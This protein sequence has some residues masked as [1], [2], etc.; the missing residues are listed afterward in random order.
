VR[1][2]ANE[3]VDRLGQ[4]GHNVGELQK[5][6]ALLSGKLTNIEEELMQPKNSAHQDTENFPTKLDNQLAYIYWMLDATHNR[7]TN[8]Q[9]ERFQDLEREKEALL[10]KLQQIL[11]TD[12]AAFNTMIQE[13]GEPPII[14]PS[15]TKQVE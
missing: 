7:P 2:Q 8:G 10:A 11:D 5:A 6:A 13:T 3:L 4:A 1:Q 12:L 15:P 14:L 9:I